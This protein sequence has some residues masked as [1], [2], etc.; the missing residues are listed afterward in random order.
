M[1]HLEKVGVPANIFDDFE[2]P[3][4]EIRA[5]GLFSIDAVQRK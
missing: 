3:T 2:C 1:M 5:C 4:E